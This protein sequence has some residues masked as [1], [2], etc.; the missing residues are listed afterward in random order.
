M[1]RIINIDYI[2]RCFFEEPNKWYHVRE[3]S[4]LIKINPATISKYLN[5]LNKEEILI[6]KRERGHLLFKA[7]T[8][9]EN[10]KD[11]KKFY[12]IT[13]IKKS[14]LLEFLDKELNY[15]EAVILFGSFSKGENDKNSDIDLF[16]I[17]NLKRELNLSDFKKIFH[18]EVQLFIE[19]PKKFIEMEKNSKNLINSIL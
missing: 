14:G 12:N 16:V 4:R 5:K 9:N 3:L 11:K 17:S 18:R 7:D 10:Y 1:S 8:E 19:T 2:L 6:K 13:L 15:P